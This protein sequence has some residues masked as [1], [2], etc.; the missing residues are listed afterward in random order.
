MKTLITCA[1]TTIGEICLPPFELRVGKVVCFQMPCLAYSEEEK[2]IIQALTGERPALGLHLSGRV[3][4][5]DP[6]KGFP[7]SFFQKLLFPFFQPRGKAWPEK[8]K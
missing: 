2:R 3:I 7:Q 8:R 5:T 4:C 6:E 1:G